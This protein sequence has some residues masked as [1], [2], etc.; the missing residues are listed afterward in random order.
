[1]RNNNKIEFVF[2]LFEIA[3]LLYLYQQLQRCNWSP[4]KTLMWTNLAVSRGWCDVAYINTAGRL[5]VIGELFPNFK[6]GFNGRKFEVTTLP[7]SKIRTRKKR[8]VG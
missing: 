2:V 8:L 1:M 4:L 5:N 7:V 3:V 6:F